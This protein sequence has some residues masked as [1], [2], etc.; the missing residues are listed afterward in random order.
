VKPNQDPAKHHYIPEFYLRRWIGA[1]GRLDRYD[2]PIPGKIMVR[3][4]YPSEVGFERHLYTSLAE[5]ESQQN[6]M[7]TRLFQVIDSRA[8][9]TLEKLN[10]N[11]AP[12]LSL[13]DM[14]YWSVFIRSLHHRTPSRLR[15][16]KTSGHSQWLIAIDKAKSQYS[17]LKSENDPP[18]FEEYRLLHTSETV[19]LLV[20]RVLP[21]I[22]FGERV[23]IFLNN[24]HKRIYRLPDGLPDYLISDAMLA[25]SNGLQ[26]AGGHY[27]IPLSPRSLLIAAYEKD[28]IVASDEMEPY[29]MLK[30]M[31]R[32]VVGRARYF[33]GARDRSQDRFIRN[34]FGQ[35]VEEGA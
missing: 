18:T 6:W 14:S 16:F 29:E 22:L 26:V 30:A 33:V 1:D 34:R 20:L 3:R 5:P 31:N 7:E 28:T 19:D 13:E 21:G 25:M 35:D 17:T 23:G 2:R 24:L 12:S 10:Q 9:K 27:A 11:P 4:S 8:A 15:D 32:W